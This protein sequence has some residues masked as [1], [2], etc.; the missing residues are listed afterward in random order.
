MSDPR[1]SI[2]S[3]FPTHKLSQIDNVRLRTLFEA[4]FENRESSYALLEYLAGVDTNLSN[5]ELDMARI[6][7]ES[8]HG[9]TDSELIASVSL[10][11]FMNEYTSYAYDTSWTAAARCS[12][13]GIADITT[14]EAAELAS[15]KTRAS[16]RRSDVI[17]L[18]RLIDIAAHIH[19]AQ[20]SAFAENTLD[21]PLSKMELRA[22]VG[23]DVPDIIK[24]MSNR[25]AGKSKHLMKKYGDILLRTLTTKFRESEKN[26][27]GPDQP[28]GEK[29]IPLQLRMECQEKQNEDVL[30]GPDLPIRKKSAPPQL[31]DECWRKRN[32]NSLSG[33]CHSCLKSLEHRSMEC[34]HVIAESKGGATT[35]NNLEPICRG[36]NNHMG[37]MNMNDYIGQPSMVD[38]RNRNSKTTIK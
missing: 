5:L 14:T 17:G 15:F 6:V 9:V 29:T 22:N 32:G 30:S 36:C 12:Y 8:L 35:L 26:L 4:T 11:D 7:L 37:T 3:K 33:K 10:N 25:L 19:T 13:S 18:L 16:M 21:M 28:V 20:T 31:R 23:W 38:T 24:D 34:G 1:I 2:L 27:S